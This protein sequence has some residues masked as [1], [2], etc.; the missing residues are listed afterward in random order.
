MS[1]HL[2]EISILVD[3]SGSMQGRKELFARQALE[4]FVR[5]CPFQALVDIIGWGTLGPTGGQQ[6]GRFGGWSS[7]YWGTKSS[8][9]TRWVTTWLGFNG[10]STSP[11]KGSPLPPFESMITPLANIFLFTVDWMPTKLL[12]LPFEVPALRTGFGNSY[13]KLFPSPV[14]LEG[15]HF[16]TA[17]AHARTLEANLGGTA[18][19]LQSLRWIWVLETIW[20]PKNGIRL[21]NPP[22]NRR[23]E[24]FEMV[25]D[26]SEIYQW[27]F[28][29]SLATWRGFGLQDMV[30][31]LVCTLPTGR[32]LRS[33][34][35]FNQVMDRNGK[36]GLIQRFL[37]S[38]L[39]HWSTS[40]PGSWRMV[41]IV[42]SWFWLMVRF[43][44]PTMSFQWQRPSAR[45][46]GR[47]MGTMGSVEEFLILMVSAQYKVSRQEMT[48]NGEPAISHIM[49][50]HF[51]ITGLFSKC[52]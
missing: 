10:F 4:H 13:E 18:T 12:R 40:C 19:C 38:W 2:Q 32:F 16:H 36:L 46:G 43:G 29:P 6:L 14:Q 21:G 5:S 48:W 47:G 11:K 3:R 27:D 42:A 41:F 15:E 30:Q 39:D 49:S 24:F 9:V 23:E 22:K 35:H 52:Q 25:E 7:A 20:G 33:L 17:L 50:R 28:D 51:D 26:T 1:L 37:R 44:I 34:Q 45:S 8:S 31:K